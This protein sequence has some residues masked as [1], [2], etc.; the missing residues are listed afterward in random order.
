M[1]YYYCNPTGNITILVKETVP[2]EKQPEISNQ[3]CK[4]EPTCEQVGFLYY[5]EKGADI[6][7]RM[8][9]G[10]F[11]GNA[12]MSTAAL[13][14]L[15]SDLEVGEKKSVLVSVSGAKEPLNVDVE[16]LSDKDFCGRVEM[17]VPEKMIVKELLFDGVSYKISIVMFEGMYHIIFPGT[18]EKDVAEA[19]IKCWCRELN[20]PA[21]G[22]MMVDEEKDILTPLVYVPDLDSFYWEHSCG[23]GT[24]A[25][26]FYYFKKSGTNVEKNFQEPSG[27]LTIEVTENGRLY[28][29][30][31]V[32]LEG[33]RST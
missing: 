18:M 33:L 28:L 3:L 19:A 8:A 11:C 23:S 22:I 13:F 20:A 15:D 9:G 2:V 10:E 5:D 6:R 1:E 12:T 25:A 26:G 21:L 27:I 14:C 24:A 31:K 30:G 32:T 17:P 4:K 16:R 7:L 29:S